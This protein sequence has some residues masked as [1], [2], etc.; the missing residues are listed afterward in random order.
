M[1]NKIQ[2]IFNK[3]TFIKVTISSILTLYCSYSLLQS[4]FDKVIVL[5]ASIT[6]LLSIAHT[7][8][9]K[10][11]FQELTQGNSTEEKARVTWQIISS[12]KK[13]FKNV[14]STVKN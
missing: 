2:L 14:T 5:I 12:T 6:V 11:L 3:N 13:H 8:K 1:F 4:E 9:V 10:D 7:K